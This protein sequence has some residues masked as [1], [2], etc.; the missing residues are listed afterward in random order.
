[1]LQK[2]QCVKPGVDSVV[3]EGKGRIMHDV[4][5]DWS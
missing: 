3:D 4:E 1:M 5:P 2:E